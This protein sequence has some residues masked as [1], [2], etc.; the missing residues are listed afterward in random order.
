MAHEIYSTDAIVI[1]TQTD[2]EESI[3]AECLTADLGRIYVHFQ[4]AKKIVNKHRMHVLPFSQITLDAVEGKQYFR[5]TGV[6]ERCGTY[7]HVKNLSLYRRELLRRLFFLVQQLVPVH[8][9]IPEIFGWYEFFMDRCFDESLS[10]TVLYTYFLVTRLRILGNLGYWNSAW[11][12][13]VFNETGKTF[14][15]VAENVKS[16]EKL[17]EKILQETQLHF[18]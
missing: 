4:G 17:I 2:G 14:T 12:D 16:T 1:T 15:Y 10:D 13:Q 8:N 5:C 9:P 3:S 6:A 7:N 11:D 18:Q